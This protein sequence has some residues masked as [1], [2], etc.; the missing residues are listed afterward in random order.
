VKSLKLYGLSLLVLGLGLF[1]LRAGEV[2]KSGT[3]AAKFLSIG[4]GPRAIAMGGAYSAV[5][6][7]ITSMYWNPAGLAQIK[8]NQFIVTQSN[9]LADI[10]INYAAVALNLGDFGNVGLNISTMTMPEMDVTTEY[11]PEGTGET[12]GAG[13][14]ALGVSYSRYLYQ[15]FL[16]GV[17]VKYVR[18]FI[19]ESIAQG[20]AMDIGTIF[21]TPFWGVRFSTSIRNFGTKMQMSGEDLLF[22]TGLDQ[23]ANGSNDQLDV[24]LGT[25]PFEL[26]LHMQIGVARDFR[27][28]SQRLTLAVDAAHPND[29]TEYLNLGGELAMLNEMV[30]IRGG[31]K[32]LFISDREEGMTIGGGFRYA[33]LKPMI[34][35]FD[36][37]FQHM[38]H[39][40]DIH[41][42]GMIFKF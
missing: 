13:S 33:N 41:T 36:Y 3:T 10:K 35:H 1:P 12:F 32:S 29:N 31:Y 4:M 2:T 6:D 26:P 28:A 21:N 39:L 37:A 20:V 16:I 24:Y 18:E 17:N 14:F 25:D 30:F 15:Q 23:T 27:I 38:A 11:Y 7:D 9:W 42:F 19:S 40:N 22:Q 5:T 34:L 8:D